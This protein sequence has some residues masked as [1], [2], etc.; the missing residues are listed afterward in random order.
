VVVG[1][2]LTEYI[3]KVVPEIVLNEKKLTSKPIRLIYQKKT[4]IAYLHILSILSIIL[5]TSLTYKL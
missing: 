1:R 4:L 3:C 5:I 2:V